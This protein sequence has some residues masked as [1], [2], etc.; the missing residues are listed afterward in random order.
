MKI[1]IKS[2]GDEVTDFYDKYLQSWTLI[3]LL[4]TTLAVITLDFS[5]KKDNSY[6]KKKEVR[7]IYINR[8]DFPCSSD[9]S[10]EE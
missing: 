3:T 2:H 4:I 7:H 5:L 9:E 8:S 10:D 1:K 6:F